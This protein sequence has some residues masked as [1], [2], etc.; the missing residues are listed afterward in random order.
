MKQKYG[1]FK[2][3]MANYD[4]FDF[5][6]YKEEVTVKVNGYVNT[7]IVRETKANFLR[8]KV[9]YGITA[10]TIFGFENLVSLVLY[11][12]YSD[13]CTHFSGTFRQKTSHESLSSITKRNSEYWWL[14][15]ILRET[16]E[17]FGGMSRRKG[18][19]FGPFFCGMSVVMNMPSFSINLCSP[20]STSAQIEIAM[21][22][23]GEKGI[24][25]QFDNPEMEMPY[26]NL[27]G[28]DCS[29]LSRYKEEDE[30]Y[31]FEIKKMLG[32]SDFV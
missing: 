7:D 32:F 29:W 12:D 5:R 25:I 17:I 19:L 13:L 24:I 8:N 10:E 11:T 2:E 6:Q 28:F 30:R 1:S 16:V 18:T 21:R 20:T 14:S 9:H 3:E 22:F 23:S 4:L 15:K 27:S 31:V 26:N